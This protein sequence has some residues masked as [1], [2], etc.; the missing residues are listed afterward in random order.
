MNA[1]HQT[2]SIFVV[3]QSVVESPSNEY[4]SIVLCKALDEAAEYIL[5]LGSHIC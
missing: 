4:E 1:Y 5:N 3:V 2:E